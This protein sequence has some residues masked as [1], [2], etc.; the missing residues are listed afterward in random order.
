MLPTWFIS[1]LLPQLAGLILKENDGKFLLNEYLPLITEALKD[2]SVSF[3]DWVE[4]AR[5]FTGMMIKILY[6]FLWEEEDLTPEFIKDP[7]LISLGGYAIPIVNIISDL[8]SDQT[9]TDLGV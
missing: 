6:A 8:I 9:Q 2:V 3:W 4:L 7:T 1:Y 5:L